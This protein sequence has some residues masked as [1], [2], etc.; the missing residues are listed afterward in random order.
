[1]CMFTNVCIYHIERVGT[2]TKE[3]EAILRNNDVCTL[4]VKTS[5]TRVEHTTICQPQEMNRAGKIF[6][7]YLMKGAYELAR[8]CAYKFSG[9]PQDLSDASLFNIDKHPVFVSSD[10]ISFEYPVTVGSI[11]MHDSMIACT[12]LKD[13]QT[14]SRNDY[15]RHCMCIIVRTRIQEPGSFEAKLSNLFTFV[16]VTPGRSL[17]QVLPTTYEESMMYLHGRRALNQTAQIAL[18]DGCLL[19][20]FL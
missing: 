17:K 8:S 11:I 5:D 13:Y 18:R 9:G 16:F 3:E 12:D 1:M 10:E 20:Q 14:D 7:G 6:G 4:T 19:A 2:L 15:D